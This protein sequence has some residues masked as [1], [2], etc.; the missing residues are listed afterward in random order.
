MADAF[1]RH[2]QHELADRASDEA[3]RR[4]Q[5]LPMPIVAATLIERL[6]NVANP[7]RIAGLDLERVYR[8]YR[9]SRELSGISEGDDFAA[10]VWARY[11]R[12][13]GDP[14]RAGDEAERFARARSDPMFSLAAHTLIEYAA[15]A[16]ETC[17]LAG[18]MVLILRVRTPA[19]ASVASLSPGERRMVV[20][21]ALLPL[22][23]ALPLGGLAGVVERREALPTLSDSFGHAE[24]L[25]WVDWLVSEHGTQGS[26]FAAAVAHHYAGES[27][28]ARTLYRTLPD[29][30]RAV[31]NLAALDAG[32]LVP[33]ES[34]TSADLDRA[35]SSP[36]PA[37]PREWWRGA[38][39]A[40]GTSF[41]ISVRGLC[42]LNLTVALALLFAFAR[43]PA[44]APG[45]Q[46]TPHPRS[47]AVAL[48]LSLLPGSRDISRGS[49][50]RGYI[51]ASL[52]L[53]PANL[54]A[55]Q[56]YLKLS[57]AREPGLGLSTYETSMVRAAALPTPSGRMQ[58][59]LL[60]PYH[61]WTILWA[62]PYA[63]LFFAI[64]GAAA[65]ASLALHG[66]Q[67]RA[68]WRHRS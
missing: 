45:S 18:W 35:L 51:T 4:R 68:M 16:F 46:V 11:F 29:D 41:G 28:R 44:A 13:R 58:E 61:Y 31:R 10:A 8:W 49:L 64:V 9:R 15:Y 67:V 40:W 33:P 14:V 63:P 3:L 5:R 22:A 25:Q 12:N 43:I 27:D 23:L 1:E 47:R 55:Q 66:R 36:L 39:L 6:V 53:L 38:R 37:W 59:G 60:T 30:P 57:G 56:A 32:S 7:E 19:R 62:Y 17:W 26:R 24:V 52:F 21:A 20:A 50:W 42:V 2:A 34:L 65:I 48:G 54:A